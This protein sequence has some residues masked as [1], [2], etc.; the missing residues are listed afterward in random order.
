MV[1][2]TTLAI[3]MLT[4][5]GRVRFKG[6]LPGGIVAVFLG[7]VLSWATGLAPVGGATGASRPALSRSCFR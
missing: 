4:Y 7:T 1:G 3:V 6:H 2:L 5:F